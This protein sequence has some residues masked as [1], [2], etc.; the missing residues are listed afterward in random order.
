MGK[1]KI[2]PSCQTKNDPALL[3]CI[4]CEA[5]LTRVRITDEDAGRIEKGDDSSSQV[6]VKKMVRV[7]DCGAKNPVNARKC[8]VCGE[9]ISDITPISDTSFDNDRRET[10]PAF[11][12]SSLDGA[13]AF[14]VDLDE[15]VI[16]R[17]NVMQD[18]LAGKSYV[19]RSHAK[20][21][22][23]GKSLFVENLSNTNFTYV[24]NKKVIGR[25]KLED[26]DELELGGTSLN[27]ERQNEAAYFLVRIGTCM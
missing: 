21:Y 23:E 18:Y 4:N 7:C 13:Y 22:I 2:C 14:K 3:E 15:V 20:L 5:D 1:Y 10:S 9:E 19:S 27:G 17:E 24:N 25:V 16:G 8:G 11:V 6:A 26:G 12:L